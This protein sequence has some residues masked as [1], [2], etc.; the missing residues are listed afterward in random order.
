[1]AQLLASNEQITV[2]KITQTPIEKVS[3]GSYSENKKD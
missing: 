3:C 2:P 1:M